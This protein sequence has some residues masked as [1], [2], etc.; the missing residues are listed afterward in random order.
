MPQISYRDESGE[1]M[2]D[3]PRRRGGLFIVVFLILALV[4]GLVGAV[5]GI[6]LVSS[7]SP[8]GAK[9]RSILGIK[10]G[11]T[12]PIPTTRTDKIVLEESSA[13]I[14]ATKKVNPAVVSII[15]TRNIS[16]FFG[17]SGSQQTGAGSGFIVTN[18]GLILTNKHV[19]SD[20]KASYT[21]FTYDGKNYPA[22]VVDTDPANDIAVVRI[23][24][25]GLPIL[26]LGDSDSVQ[27][28]QWVI[29][30]GNAL[31]E[32]Q[33][34]VTVGVISAKDRHITTSDQTGTQSEILDGLLQT[35]A[36]INLGNS[37]GPLVDLKGRAIGIN[38]VMASSAENIGFAISINPAK[39]A[40]QSIQK[41]GRIIRPF[42][43]VS[44]QPLNKEI[45]S[46][47]N[48]P[49][50]SGAWVIASRGSAI[51]ADSPAQ[52]AGIKDN[53]IIVEVNGEKIDENHSLGGYLQ[54]YQPGEEVTLKII[55]GKEELTL[56]V[57]LVEFKS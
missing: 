15:A 50:D 43:G 1:H 33:N 27:V 38:T 48:L 45:A 42:L 19:V 36:A 18:D 16:D 26:D 7:S 55:R 53:D 12:I 14:D 20:T 40:L 6:V 37:G 30:I 11:G 49:T 8:V 5:G 44:Y 10:D 13:I 51:V 28:G 4:M 34:T 9:M 46:Q 56:K 52:K 22:E 47:N 39:T 25:T 31:G 21:V 54:Q 41:N 3:R 32:F 17:N 2:L 35:D 29:A 23:K 57:K 24:A